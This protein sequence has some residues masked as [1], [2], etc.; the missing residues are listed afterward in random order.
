MMGNAH[1]IEYLLGKGR[2][3]NSSRIPWQDSANWIVSFSIRELKS[4]TQYLGVHR[5]HVRIPNLMY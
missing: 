3:R 5:L 1:M 2:H 4:G